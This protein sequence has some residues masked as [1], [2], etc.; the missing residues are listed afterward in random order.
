M[1]EKASRIR[2]ENYF[3]ISGWM[4]NKL[5]LKGIALEVFAIVYGFSQDGSSRFT[6]SIQYLCDFTGTSKPTVMKALKELTDKEYLIKTE[7]NKNGVKFNEYQTNL[8]VVKKLYH[9]DKETLQEG[10]KETLPNNISINN[11]DNNIVKERK[12]SEEGS[13]SNSIGNKNNSFDK[14]INEYLTD[15]ES[16][17]YHDALERKEL[18]IEWL[19]V[20]KAKRAALTDKAI[21]MNIAK[22]DKLAAESNMS[23]IEY[24]EEV[25]C[26]GWAAFYPITNYKKDPKAAT[27]NA[28]NKKSE[29]DSFMAE[30]Q[31]MYEG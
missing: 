4:L 31:E 13:R 3:Q 1:A 14:I 12:T 19:K 23:V 28:V 21:Q 24:L 22:L 7:I 8:T 26:R 20:R 30:L 15:G 27:Q 10:S 25:I 2:D 29:Y 5:K 18:L 17:K 11:I 9:P 16:Y 6:G